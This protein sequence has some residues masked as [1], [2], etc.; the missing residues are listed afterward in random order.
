M[1]CPLHQLRH[2]KYHTHVQGRLVSAN[3]KHDSHCCN[4]EARISMHILLALGCMRIPAGWFPLTLVENR[5]VGEQADISIALYATN[6]HSLL[7]KT[8]GKI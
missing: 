2:I 6:C 3:I 5:D 8:T 4:T 7:K 1:L